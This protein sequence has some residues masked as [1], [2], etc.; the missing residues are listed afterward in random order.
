MNADRL[1]T[2]WSV[3]SFSEAFTDV[4]AR[5]PRVQQRD[6]LTSGA[7]PVL[8]QGESEVAGYWDGAADATRI[9]RPLVLFGDHTRRVKYVDRDFVV[10][11]DGVKL[12]R[13]GPEVEPRFGYHW[14][15]SI[16]IPSAGYSRH[17]KFLRERA[18][19]L[20]PLPEQRRIAAI[21]DEADSLTKTALHQLRGLEDIE[22][23][24]FEAVLGSTIQASGLTL[25][26]VATDF[27]YGTSVKSG[28]RGFPVLRI[29]NVTGRTID[30]RDLK[31]VD[32]PDADRDRLT[33]GDQDVLFVRSNGNR[34]LIGRAAAFCS[35]G[36]D[37]RGDTPWVFASYLIRARLS[38]EISPRAVVALT[39]N[40]I[41]RQH[42][43]GAAATSA[44]QYNISIPT[45]K[46]LPMFEPS[47]ARQEEFDRATR[48]L[49][50]QRATQARRATDLHSLFASLQ[51]R[52]FRGE[53]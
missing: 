28:P 35:V 2:G 10:G 17:F 20:P 23:S 15:R 41:G 7:F 48:E 1:P 42:L 19:P 32:V 52:A 6:F 40:R 13:P 26:Q 37:A 21:L 22:E 27:R 3:V 49:D 16:D 5:S 18:V 53:L 9:E 29:P 12:L 31:T 39:R 36:H 11:A 51:H 50:A 45:L 8:D 25:G 38:P 44:G 43:V 30:T 33:L 14:M 24:I 47:R 46:A 34:D 4:T